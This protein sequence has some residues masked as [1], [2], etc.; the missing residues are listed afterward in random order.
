MALTA[1]AIAL[2]LATLA[3][4]IQKAQTMSADE[5]RRLLISR[6]SRADKH[7][8]EMMAEKTKTGEGGNADPQAIVDENGQNAGTMHSGSAPPNAAD[9]PAKTYPPIPQREVDALDGHDQPNVGLEPTEGGETLPAPKSA[10]AS[11][12]KK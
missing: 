12:P 8:E 10:T 11:A 7:F 9:N 5:A 4:E 3:T 1:A 2:E 6:M